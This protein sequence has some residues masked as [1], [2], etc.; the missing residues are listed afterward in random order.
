MRVKACSR[1]LD[2]L[3][4]VTQH[5]SGVM[6]QKALTLGADRRIRLEG[7]VKT[8]FGT[9]HKDTGSRLRAVGDRMFDMLVPLGQGPLVKS[10]EASKQG[11]LKWPE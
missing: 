1:S 7:V 2:F 10:T 6:C 9:C 8:V 5:C 4:G 3:P 11:S